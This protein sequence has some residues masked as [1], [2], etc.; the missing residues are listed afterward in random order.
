[1]SPKERARLYKTKP[2]IRVGGGY[3]RPPVRHPGTAGKGAWRKVRKRVD[4]VLPGVFT[5]EVREAV[6]VIGR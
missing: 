3:A 2:W 4:R 1:M 6:R 5:D